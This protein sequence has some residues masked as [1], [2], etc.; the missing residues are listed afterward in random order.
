MNHVFQRRVDCVVAAKFRM[1][2]VVVRVRLAY[3]SCCRRLPPACG[4]PVTGVPSPSQ[5]QTASAP[6]HQFTWR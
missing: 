2:N 3:S 6:S 1:G 4:R 5:S